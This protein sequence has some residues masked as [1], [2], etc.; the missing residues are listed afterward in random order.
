MTEKENDIRRHMKDMFLSMRSAGEK[1]GAFDL[2][3]NPTRVSHRL[4]TRKDWVTYRDARDAYQALRIQYKEL[5]ERGLL[6]EKVINDDS[7]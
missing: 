7:Y 6:T 3:F 1:I 4:D 2:F 5:F